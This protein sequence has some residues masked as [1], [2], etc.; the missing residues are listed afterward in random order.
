MILDDYR[1]VDLFSDTKKLSLTPIGSDY[2]SLHDNYSRSHNS[3]IV[4]DSVRRPLGIGQD[5]IY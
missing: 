2:F 3:L 4:S 5:C 1:G